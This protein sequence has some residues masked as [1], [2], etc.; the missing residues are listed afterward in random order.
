[1]KD[2]FSDLWNGS[3]YYDNKGYEL[4][5]TPSDRDSENNGGIQIYSPDEVVVKE[6]SD[7]IKTVIKCGNDY[8][9]FR[10]GQI[11][12]RKRITAEYKLALS[13]LEA[14]KEVFLKKMENDHEEKMYLFE[15]IC[16]NSKLALERGD[17]DMY[18][19]SS[20]KLLEIYERGLNKKILK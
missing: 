7:I 2:Y 6:V 10:E 13:E 9:K 17:I 4:I 8:A 5:E 20:N 1:M 15:K 11:T 14:R 18:I 19:F 3:K 12:E 16:E